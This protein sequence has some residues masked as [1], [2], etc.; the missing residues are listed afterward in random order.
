MLELVAC[1][2]ILVVVLEFVDTVVE[3]AAPHPPKV[4]SKPIAHIRSILD[5][6]IFILFHS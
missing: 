5:G 4:F 6:I 2:T 3:V 1:A